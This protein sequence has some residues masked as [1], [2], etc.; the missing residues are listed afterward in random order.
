MNTLRC[1]CHH[2][3]D[4]VVGQLLGDSI[5]LLQS[6]PTYDHLLSDKKKVNLK[7]ASDHLCK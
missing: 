2:V 3:V 7:L 5:S 4:N 6:V 1:T